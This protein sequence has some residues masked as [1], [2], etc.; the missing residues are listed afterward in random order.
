MPCIFSFVYF[1]AVTDAL[2]RNGNILLRQFSNIRPKIYLKGKNLL[3]N[4]TSLKA[5]SVK[6]HKGKVG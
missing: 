3:K 6:I 4:K 2:L 5:N 1:K